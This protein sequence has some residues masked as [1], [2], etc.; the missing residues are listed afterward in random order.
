M[1]KTYYP[2]KMKE[3]RE[4]VSV[5]TYT[6][7]QVRNPDWEFFRKNREAHE[8]SYGSKIS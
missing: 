6:L 1:Q 3:N 8:A 5:C 4:S 2:A 7:V